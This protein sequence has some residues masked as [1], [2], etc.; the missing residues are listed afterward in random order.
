MEEK[1]NVKMLEL[2][3]ENKKMKRKLVEL[4]AQQKKWQ[5]L[6]K[7]KEVW[8]EIKQ[9][10]QKTLMEYKHKK[11]VLQRKNELQL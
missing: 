8:N 11:E 5:E 4:M 9:R 10:Y 6:K 3:I 2:T 7:N 1:V